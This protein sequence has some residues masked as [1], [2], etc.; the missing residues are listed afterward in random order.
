[1]GRLDPSGRLPDWL[2]RL[3]TVGT[4]PGEPDDVRARKVTCVVTSLTI[5]VLST[6]WVSLYW[7][8]GQVVAGT[9]PFI[10]QIASIISLWIFARTKNFRFYRLSHLLLI[11]W[12]PVLMQWSLGGFKTSSAVM[13]W[14]FVAPLA[15]LL[16]A[17]PRQSIPWFASFLGLAALSG[18][19]DGY[20]SALPPDLPESLIVTFFVLNL[21]GVLSTAFVMLHYFVRS[22][23]EA[24]AELDINHQKLLA[25]Q[26]RSEQLLLNILPQPIAHRLRAGETRIAD[27]FP[28]VTVL[29]ADLVSFTQ[30]TE[31]LGPD[32][33]VLLLGRLFSALDRLAAEHGLEKI[34]TIGD[35]YMVA[36]GLPT[37]R[38]DHAE[39]IAKMALAMPR[40]VAECAMWSGED[41]Q[42]RIGIDTG[43][44][45]AGVIGEHK[46]SYDLWGDTV[47]TASRMATHGQPG[48]IQVTERLYQRLNGTFTFESRGPVDIKGKGLMNTYLL[49]GQATSTAR[50][51]LPSARTIINSSSS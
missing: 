40:A 46:F 4:I 36:G 27:G 38:P 44:V 20:F 22:R 42:T 43:P 18:V 1:M 45:I 21:S 33:I 47:N 12:L 34:K 14:A 51:P 3:V 29:F 31:R 5:V 25:E 50:S 10:Y 2:E 48:A 15:A 9:I 28:E 35:S 6:A 41:L 39:A 26:A 19:L 32:E 23:E 8:L 7:L 49:T 11:L 30:L 24:R 37:P 16:C 13:L 17:G